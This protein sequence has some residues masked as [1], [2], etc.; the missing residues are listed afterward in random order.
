MKI[1]LSKGLFN[2]SF[3]PYLMDY[4]ARTEVYY[5]GAGSGKSHFIAQKLIVKALTQK[6]RILVIRKTLA[7][8]RESCWRLI[9]DVLSSWK[10][11]QYCSVNKS[12]FTITLPNGS[13]FIFKGL[14]DPEKIKS[15][16]G[17]TDLWVEEASELSNA[18][19]FDQLQL[20]IRSRQEQTQTI[21]SYNPV[22]RANWVYERFHEHAEPGTVVHKSTYKD[23]RFLTPEYIAKLESLINTNPLYYRVYALGEFC[24]LD[25]TVFNNWEIA[26]IK[27]FPCN[28]A[29]FGL[30]FGYVNDPSAFVAAKVNTDTKQIYIFDEMY[31]VGLLNNSI[32]QW[33]KYRGYTKETI[34][35]DAAEQKSI[36]EIKRNGVDHIKPAVKGAGSIM[37]GIDLLQQYHIIVDP[38]CENMITELQNY[39]WKKDR[40][41]GEYINEPVDEYNHL[42]DAL[43]YAMQRIYKPGLR[44]MPKSVLGL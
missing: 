41:T 38:K 8:I 15:I 12:D 32:A 23:N 26:E 9:C 30:D 36:E 34:F 20:R 19:E 18:D 13:Q 39:S 25:K 1:K 14:D 4:S 21:L 31:Q 27:D 43:R 42:C 28:V 35:A 29:I 5:G 17:I 24:S 40:K 7:S 10:I 37:W 33:I 22:S 16:E 11:Y 2:E 44:T 3:Y 6:R